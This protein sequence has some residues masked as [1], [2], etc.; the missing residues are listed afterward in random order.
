MRRATSADT[1]SDAAHAACMED[2][3]AVL[4][5]DDSAFASFAAWL[6]EDLKRLEARFADYS[7]TDSLALLPSR[8]G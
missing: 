1:S 7:T 5:T 8:H 2:V 3:V 6:E 4:F